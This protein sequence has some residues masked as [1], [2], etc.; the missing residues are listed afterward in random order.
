MGVTCDMC[1]AVSEEGTAP[2]TWSLTLE[3]GRVHRYCAECTR[4]NLRAMEGKL[5]PEHW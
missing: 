5:D 4:A 2:L 3:R 1:G